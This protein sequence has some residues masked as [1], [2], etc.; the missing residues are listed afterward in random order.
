MWRL[1]RIVVS[2]LFAS[3]SL[4]IFITAIAM[5]VRSRHVRDCVV[6]T[7]STGCTRSLDSVAGTVQFIETAPA[8]SGFGVSP[9]QS[10]YWSTSRQ[11]LPPN[12]NWRTFWGTHPGD[13][14][15]GAAGFFLLSRSSLV[16][17]P[18]GFGGS[19]FTGGSGFGPAAFPPAIGTTST[20][21]LVIPYWAIALL[22]APLPIR[23]LIRLR[24][25]RR[26]RRRTRAGHCIA[27]GYDL[28]AT[29][30]R[31][32]ECGTAPRSC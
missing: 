23:G 7:A 13:I 15:W 17:P 10:P 8:A 22:A 11:A 29:P 32:P 1:I 14:T 25:W 9:P 3:I 30:D 28:R 16:Y 18:G 4:L 2:T 20:L 21:G 19:G 12:A 26:T 27:C 31:C 6:W 24:R 5:W